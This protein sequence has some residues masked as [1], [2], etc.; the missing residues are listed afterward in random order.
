MPAEITRTE[1]R[2]LDEKLAAAQPENAVF[3]SEENTR[4]D[5]R[6]EETL[7]AFS[8]DYA[9]A[10][11]QLSQHTKS[12]SLGPG[13]EGE[14]RSLAKTELTWHTDAWK[15]TGDGF[16]LEIGPECDKEDTK[17]WLTSF[18]RLQVN[19]LKRKT[20][21]QEKLR[22][23]LGAKAN[24]EGKPCV[25]FAKG[26]T[27][28]FPTAKNGKHLVATKLM[29]ASRSGGLKPID[30]EKI[31]LHEVGHTLKTYF[32]SHRGDLIVDL[33]TNGPESWISAQAQIEEIS[34]HYLGKQFQPILTRLETETDKQKHKEFA[35]SIAKE[36]FA[37]ACRHFYLEAVL[38]ASPK[39]FKKTG[40]LAFD[41]FCQDLCT[42]AI[43]T[44]KKTPIPLRETG[45]EID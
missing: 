27:V 34:P 21:K 3:Q 32:E 7:E 26:S 24:L 11:E 41:Q 39:K 17:T 42:E 6:K 43:H 19:V 37:E 14:H 20:T 30:L 28:G 29:E 15:A 18:Q 1:K 4:R 5:G 2:A 10:A 40:F 23:L 31:I 25:A 8:S 35:T 44:I 12:E 45:L 22:F 33:R 36:L 9:N 38:T 16:E 13:K